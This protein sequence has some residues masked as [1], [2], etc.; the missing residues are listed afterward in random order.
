MARADYNRKARAYFE[1]CGYTAIAKTEVYRVDP[2]K[3]DAPPGTKGFGRFHDMFGFCDFLVVGK[4][5]TVGAQICRSSD[6][7]NRLTKLVA[8]EHIDACLEAGWK[9]QVI[10]FL[11]GQRDPQRIVHVTTAMVNERRKVLAELET[12]PQLFEA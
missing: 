1:R 10:G 12:E 6:I 4:G 11:P 2:P 9:I 3:K 5:E 8:S 7:A